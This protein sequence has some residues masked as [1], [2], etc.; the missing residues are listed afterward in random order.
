MRYCCEDRGYC[1]LTGEAM[2]KRGR[3]GRPLAHAS[4][5]LLL[6]IGDL[7]ELPLRGRTV[8]GWSR[9]PQQISVYCNVM[10]ALQLHHSAPLRT[11]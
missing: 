9:D 10:F 6:F 2:A 5:S 7:P 4:A 11:P 3:L 8:Y 1:R